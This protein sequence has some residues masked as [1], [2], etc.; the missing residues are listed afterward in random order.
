MSLWIKDVA[1]EL[2]QDWQTVKRLEMDYM[3]GHR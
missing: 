2:N 1:E 3:R